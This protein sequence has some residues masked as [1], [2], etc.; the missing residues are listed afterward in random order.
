[1]GQLNNSFTSWISSKRS[2]LFITLLSLA[3]DLAVN[4][5]IIHF[6]PFTDI[7]WTAYM[8]EVGAPDGFLGGVKD[9]PLMRGDTGPLVYPAGFVYLYSLFYYITNGG[10]NFLPIQYLF[11]FLSLLTLL[12]VSLLLRMCNLPPA[13][14][15]LLTVSIRLHSIWVL[16]L[17]NDA[18]MALLCLL[19]VYLTAKKKFWL[20]SLCFSLAISIKMSGLLFLPGFFL[21]LAF[22]KGNVFK[23][24]NYLFNIFAVQVMLAY[25][26][27]KENYSGYISKAFEFSRV[28]TFKWTVNWKFLNPAV[29][30]SEQFGLVLLA[31]HLGFLLIFLFSNGAN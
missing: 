13:I 12:I 1:M 3:F 16:R 28:F 24:F 29:F 2:W 15:L 23:I 31:L 11:A 22:E 21:V 4:V 30:T 7:D 6:V 14:L 20:A 27:L 25:P 10:A 19:A 8:Q 17:F 5:F 18:P 26:F 9:Y